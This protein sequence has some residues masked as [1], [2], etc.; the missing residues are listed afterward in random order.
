VRG[1]QRSPAAMAGRGPARESAGGH[2]RVRVCPE[3]DS[4]G[5]STNTMM[6]PQARGRPTEGLGRRGG[7]VAVRRLPRGAT[8]RRTVWPRWPEFK[9]ELHM[10][11]W[12]KL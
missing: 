9:F 2:A 7:R 10:F 3:G 6:A 8:R 11:E 1:A 5:G 12:F 4:L